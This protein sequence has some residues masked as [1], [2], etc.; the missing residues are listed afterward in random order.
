MNLKK[1]VH[2]V[3]TI[4]CSN[5]IH[6]GF[7]CMKYIILVNEDYV[8]LWLDGCGSN[9]NRAGWT[10]SRYFP[11]GVKIVMRVRRKEK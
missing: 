5:G 7:S 4:D 9:G 11:S 6:F 1:L 3:E 8:D 10:I 2:A